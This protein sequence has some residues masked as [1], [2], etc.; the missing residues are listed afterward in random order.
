M[1]VGVYSCIHMLMYVL[2]I[3]MC[4]DIYVCMYVWEGG[5]HTVHIVC[6]LAMYTVKLA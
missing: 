2:F 1:F 5:V 6:N 4:E 3:S